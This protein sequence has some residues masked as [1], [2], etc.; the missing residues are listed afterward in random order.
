[1][2]FKVGDRV[3]VSPNP[4]NNCATFNGMKVDYFV[5]EEICY[6]E[7]YR[8]QGYRNEMSVGTCFMC[9]KDEDFVLLDNKTNNNTIMTTISSFIKK[10]TR[11]EPEATFVKA[12]FLDENENLTAKGRE[13]LEYVTWEANKDALKTLAD[14]IFAEDEKN[15]K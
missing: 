1:M 10:I 2:K 9:Y 14:Q 11:K 8:Y 12:G 6:G 5:I 3:K 15:S 7:N 4:K 13:A